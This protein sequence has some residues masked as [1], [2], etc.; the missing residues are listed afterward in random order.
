LSIADSERA[1]G[2]NLASHK[3]DSALIVEELF[4]ISKGTPAS[5]MT[6]PSPAQGDS[7]WVN[8]NIL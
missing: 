4:T 8:Q 6:L 7:L 5:S 2:Q 1:V 3:Q